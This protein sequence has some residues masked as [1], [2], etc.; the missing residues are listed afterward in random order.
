MVTA[1]GPAC[2]GQGFETQLATWTG[3]RWATTT[4]YPAATASDL[5]AQLG[6][7]RSVVKVWFTGNDPATT[8]VAGR[9]ADA[10]QAHRWNPQLPQP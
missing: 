9:T 3:L 1:T 4:L 8:T 2:R 7:G 5:F 6:Q 10:L